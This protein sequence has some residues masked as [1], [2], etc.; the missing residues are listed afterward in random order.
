[1]GNDLAGYSQ[2][3]IERLKK[4]LNI[5]QELAYISLF[6]TL[7]AKHH[8]TVSLSLQH[9]NHQP[10]KLTLLTTLILLNSTDKIT[11][12]FEQNKVE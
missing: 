8:M 1:M 2:N 11:S 4:T 10:A 12:R 9:G 5:V 3:A 7:K 6:M